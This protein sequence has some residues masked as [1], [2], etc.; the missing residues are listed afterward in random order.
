M[1]D[2]KDRENDAEST[3]SGPGSYDKQETE[4]M[5]AFLENVFYL[6]G[7]PESVVPAAAA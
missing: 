3:S 7:A 4:V 2:T 1:I 5:D 6:I